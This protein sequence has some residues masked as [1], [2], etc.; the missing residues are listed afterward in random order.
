[1]P[2]GVVSPGTA[3]QIHKLLVDAVDNAVCLRLAVIRAAVAVPQIVK[4]AFFIHRLQNQVVAVICKSVCHLLPDTG[5]F[6]HTGVIVR[7]KSCDPA[8]VPVEIHHRI[9]AVVQHILCHRFH[10]V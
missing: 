5:I 10:T 8:V 3:Y 6:F 9:H 2:L 7:G 4:T 1:M